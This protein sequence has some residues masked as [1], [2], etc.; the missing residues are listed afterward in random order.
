MKPLLLLCLLSLQFSLTGQYRTYTDLTNLFSQQLIET[1]DEGLLLIASEDCYTP[2]SITIE[3]C[4][5]ALHLVRTNSQGDTIWTRRI[6]FSG[7]I[8]HIQ[9]N[10]DGS[11]T[12]FGRVHDNYQCDEILVGLFGFAAIRILNLSSTGELQSTVQ[13]P[14]TCALELMDVIP[15]NDTLFAAI[16]MYSNLNYWT[17]PYEGRLMIMN[18]NGQ[19][20]EEIIMPGEDWAKAWLLP[21]ATDAFEFLYLDTSHTFH[22]VQYNTQL[23][24]LNHIENADAYMPFFEESYYRTD[25]IK[26]ANND[27][28]VSCREYNGSDH[29]FHVLRFTPQ[30]EL[31]SVNSNSF[32]AITDMVELPNGEF[33]ICARGIDDPVSHRNTTLVYLSEAG[34]FYN[35]TIID[36]PEFEKPTQILR[37]TQ[38]SIV[39]TGNINCCNMHD[40]IGPGKSFLLFG[41]FLS[42]STEVLF[43]QQSFTLFPNPAG[44]QLYIQSNENTIQAP[45][46]ILLFDPLGR[47]VFK[48]PT[49]NINEPVNISFVDKGIYIYMLLNDNIPLASGKLVKL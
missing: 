46:Q 23:V 8:V 37:T 5:Y 17:T 41:D 29:F 16:A 3:G 35:S 11:F 15:L 40:T 48:N 25:A 12:L 45:D 1:R 13:F 39:I 42:T 6:G 28:C 34:A 14:E 27:I 32:N 9:E 2:G 21:Y 10:T 44:Q 30:L 31:E 18:K 22:L 26:T 43:A 19:I 36:Y 33:L 20:K 49:I 38:D 47:L 24:E 4:M 7:T